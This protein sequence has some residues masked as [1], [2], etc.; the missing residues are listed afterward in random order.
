M[1][2]ASAGLPIVSRSTRSGEN[3]ATLE[4]VETD[5]IVAKLEL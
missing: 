5:F 1:Q 4:K 3:L 2:C